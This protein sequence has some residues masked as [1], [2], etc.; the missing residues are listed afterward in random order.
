MRFHTNKSDVVGADIL[1][2]Q[3]NTLFCIVD[4]YSKSPVVKEIHNLSAENLIRTVKIVCKEFG[5]SRKIL[6]DADTNFI[7]DKFRQFCRQLKIDQAITS[8]YHHQGNEQVEWYIKFMKCTIKK[9]PDNNDDVNLALLQMGST[10]ISTEP[11]SPATILFNRPIRAML[12]Q[13]NRKPIT[14]NAD[15]EHYDALKTLKGMIF[16]KSHFLSL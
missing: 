16:I 9:C 12:P 4:Y 15:N 10:P 13:I 2:I 1:S 11:T 6:S 8:S 3:N 14:C 7:L 5:L